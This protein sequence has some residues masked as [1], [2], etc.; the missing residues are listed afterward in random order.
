MRANAFILGDTGKKIGTDI[1]RIKGA[2]PNSVI[3]ID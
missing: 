1:S 3:A 2:K